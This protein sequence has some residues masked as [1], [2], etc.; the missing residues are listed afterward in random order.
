MSNVDLPA[1]RLTIS[2]PMATA[3]EST[4]AAFTAS[5]VRCGTAAVHA[6]GER[7]V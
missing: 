3:T 1:S 5:H 7:E 2:S 4:C 6:N